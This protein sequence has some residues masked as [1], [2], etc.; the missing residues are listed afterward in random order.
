MDDYNF[1]RDLFDTY[2]SLPP[3]IQFAWFCGIVLAY[4]GTAAL[5]TCAV[6]GIAGRRRRQ[7]RRGTPEEVNSHST[8]KAALPDGPEPSGLFRFRTDDHGGLYLEHAGSVPQLEWDGSKK[9]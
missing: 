2:Q 1:W 6:L 7:R 8:A 9:N 3:W 5:A 4:I